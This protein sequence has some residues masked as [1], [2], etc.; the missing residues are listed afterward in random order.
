[1]SVGTNLAQDRGPLLNLVGWIL[2]IIALL[3][4]LVKFYIKWR[5]FKRLDLNDL[6]FAFALLMAIA[7][8]AATAAQVSNGLGRTARTPSD[9]ETR[10]FYLA[11]YLSSLFYVLAT[12]FIKLG[13]LHFFLSLALSPLSKLVTNLVLGFSS[14]W[15]LI[16]VLVLSFQCSLPNT[17]DM[18]Q[19]EG[20][21]IN[22]TSF[23]IVHGV[24][25]II[26]QTVV[27]FLPIYLLHDIQTNKRTKLFV[28]LSFCPNIATLPPIILRLTYLKHLYSFTN[29]NVMTVS[30]N[31][32]LVTV[33]H[34]N[35]AIIFGSIP[36]TKPVI[37][38]LSIGVITND[39]GFSLRWDLHTA[40]VA[41]AYG[42]QSSSSGRGGGSSKRALY[43]WRKTPAGESYTSSVTASKGR[44]ERGGIE[45]ESMRKGNS[46]V[47]VERE[48]D[49]MEIRTTKTTT[50]KS[51]R[52]TDLEG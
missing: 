4:C 10:N 25:D 48:G 23:W 24:V 27:A 3:A 8:C 22:E 14:S 34:S 51:E 7:L 30:F 42:N 20:K 6:F 21:C 32:I 12:F 29:S 45:L 11:T 49:K 17:W 19:G 37:D 15:M 50:V 13:T 35:I 44:E 5:A 52:R 43:G 41:T 36:F 1:M 33:I 28:R 39:I 16:S 26:T 47:D 46:T 40:Q 31:L 9:S 18:R 38:A 2:L